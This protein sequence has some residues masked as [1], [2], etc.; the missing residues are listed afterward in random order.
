MTAVEHEAQVIDPGGGPIRLRPP[1]H[2]DA[3]AVVA[4]CRDEVTQQTL[5]TIP[6]D[7][8][9]ADALEWIAA[10]EVRGGTWAIADQ[11]SDDFLGSIALTPLSS[12]AHSVGYL[13]APEARGR[14]VAT[15]ALRLLTGWAFNEG[16]RRV[17]LSHLT[18]NV[19]SMRVAMAAGFN[20]EGVRRGGNIGRD[21]SLRDTAVWGRLATDSGDAVVRVLPDLADDALTDGIVAL[22]PLRADDADDMFA[23]SQLPEVIATTV[24]LTPPTIERCRKR[25]AEAGYRWLLGQEAQFVI[26][27]AATMA[28]A[29]LISLH[30]EGITRQFMFGYD[31]AREFRGRGFAPRAV[32]L[33]TDW[34]FAEVHAA[35][36]V[37][38]TAP[39]NL[40]SQRVMEKAGFTREGF[41]RARLPR[42]D[43]PGRVDNVAWALLPDDPR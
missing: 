12:H 13:V 19:A 37:A 16:T 14:G 41:E 7:Y 20:H 1:R 22:T 24:A 6:A 23:I 10:A 4:A 17:E 8:S 42:T 15:A 25:C 27:D 21:N 29:G 43:R 3:D 11:A 36:L 35:R 26:R 18:T 9:H 33:L 32:R 34:A 5:G 28:F 40:A 31:V 30:G 38:G 2:S 39:D